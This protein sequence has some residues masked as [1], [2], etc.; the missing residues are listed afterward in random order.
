MRGG[1]WRERERKRERGRGGVSERGRMERERERGEVVRKTDRGGVDGGL[2]L[3]LHVLL[4][5]EVG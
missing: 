1:E 5:V 2:C 4:E 3:Y